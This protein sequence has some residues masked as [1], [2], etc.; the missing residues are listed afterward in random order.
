MKNT[1]DATPETLPDPLVPVDCDL[2]GL[3]YMPLDTVA[4]L[5]SDLFALANGDELKAA[6]TL[7]CRSWNQVPA[8]SLPDNERVLA[9]LSMMGPGWK[10]VR[11]IALH[12]W[13]K[14]SDGR[15][16]HPILAPKAIKAWQGRCAQRK[17]AEAR[18]AK[19]RGENVKKPPSCRGISRGNASTSISSSINNQSKDWPPATPPAEGFAFAVE[20]DRRVAGAS[21]PEAESVPARTPPATPPHRAFAHL[22]RVMALTGRP[23]RACRGLLGSWRKKLGDDVDEL[24]TLL[25]ECERQDMADPVAWMER[26]I[27]RTTGRPIAEKHKTGVER[28][29]DETLVRAQ[30]A[31]S[32]LFDEKRD[33]GWVNRVWPERAAALGL[34]TCPLTRKDY[35]SHFARAQA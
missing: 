31:W 19:E 29:V 3:P 35:E 28:V 27:S 33:F 6:L 30:R 4:L 16:Y 11:E 14:C 25:T 10:D 5:E 7:W 26:A 17:R 13:V 22:S 32:E 23:E 24:S 12:G 15:L 2:R 20:D 9:H 34:P 18:W 21:C 1:V 8:G